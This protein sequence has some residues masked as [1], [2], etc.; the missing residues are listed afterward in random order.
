MSKN[1]DRG[2]HRFALVLSGTSESDERLEDALFEAGCDDAILAFRSGVGYLEFDR[3]AESLES[4]VLS[5]VRDVLRA[6]HE[7]T[8]SHVEPD[9]LVNASEIARRLR[10]TR[11]YVR[12]LSVGAR[13]PGGFPS[14][15]SGVT[16][17]LV[18]WSWASVVS[19]LASHEKITDESVLEEAET[20]R[21]I[22]GV[23]E[24]RLHPAAIKRQ[25]ELSRKLV[26]VGS[27]R[28]AGI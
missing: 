10:K 4:A 23:L 27:S 14:P 16:G 1:D 22:N 12:L 18:L 3:E 13:G 19:W 11:E 15:L 7:V 24:S 6:K 21:D 17:T 25:D 8:V 28:A 9:D 2:L 26:G 5:A 20:I